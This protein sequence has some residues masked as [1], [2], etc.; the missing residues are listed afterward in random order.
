MAHEMLDHT[1]MRYWIIAS[2]GGPG[3]TEIDKMSLAVEQRGSE[4]VVTVEG[5]VTAETS[6]HLRSVLFR[7]I[8]KHRSVA[9]DI[10]ISEVTY[11]D[12]SGI[13]TLLEALRLSASRSVKLR[14]ATVAGQPAVLAKITE[15]ATIF[16]AAGSEVV[17][18]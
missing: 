8:K 11:L 3:P 13:A 10:N 1:H 2:P 4:T 18:A 17:F 12:T 5:R 7:L 6:P 16:A 9:I 15:L 14:L